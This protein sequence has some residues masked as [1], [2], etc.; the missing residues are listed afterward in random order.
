MLLYLFIGTIL[1]GICV[2]IHYE[3][4]R[5]AALSILPRLHLRP[6][7]V[8]VLVG[9][10]ACMTAHVAEIWM[11]AIALYVLSF[12]GLE[13]GYDDTVRRTFFD[14]LNNSADSYTSLGYS[15]IAHLPKAHHLLN[16][17]EALAGLVMIAWTASFTFLLMERYWRHHLPKSP[18]R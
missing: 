8:L 12:L 6:A 5:F 10:I 7:R 1:V 9:V 15:D 11:F 2:I 16:G 13:F 17:V 18:D 14:F 3:T 4:L